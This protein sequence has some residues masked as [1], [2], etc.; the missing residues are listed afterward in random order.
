MRAAGAL[1][2]GAAVTDDGAYGDQAGLIG[3]SFRF[4]E[5]IADR[6]GVIAVGDAADVPTHSAKAARDVFRECHIGG[7]VKSD[8]VVVIEED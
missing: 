7:A 2:V 4:G 8:L 6:G 1:F 3:D 5:R